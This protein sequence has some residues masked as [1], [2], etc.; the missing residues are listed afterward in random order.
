MATRSKTTRGLGVL[1]PYCLD[2]DN[3]PLLG[4]GDLTWSCPN[5]DMTWTADEAWSRLAQLAGRW[6]KVA[7]WLDTA[8]T[9]D[10][11]E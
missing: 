4:S 10:T 8:P 1:C 5:C 11:E 2:P 3:A 6:Q 9:A 7:T